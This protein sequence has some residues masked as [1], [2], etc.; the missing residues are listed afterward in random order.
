MHQL[1]QITTSVT[2]LTILFHGQG[3]DENKL[4]DHSHITENYKIMIIQQ[5]FNEIKR[6]LLCLP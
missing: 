2:S 3:K 6:I 4:I 1:D 5:T